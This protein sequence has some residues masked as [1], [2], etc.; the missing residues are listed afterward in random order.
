MWQRLDDG[1][2]HKGVACAAPARRS[3]LGVR[4]GDP[5]QRR[6]DARSVDPFRRLVSDVFDFQL[7]AGT[8]VR[9]SASQCAGF[10][11]GR[12][13]HAS[14]AWAF[15]PDRSGRSRTVPLTRTRIVT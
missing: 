6:S 1:C 2:A 3:H 12:N 15:L 4:V 10:K 7:I 9:M 8:I 11:S 5:H 13:V 14:R